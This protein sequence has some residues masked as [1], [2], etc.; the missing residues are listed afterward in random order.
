MKNAISKY[1]HVLVCICTCVPSINQHVNMI[2]CKFLIFRISSLACLPGA[3]FPGDGKTDYGHRSS[4]NEF[5]PSTADFAR[6][7]WLRNRCAA[8]SLFWAQCPLSLDDKGEELDGRLR[9][10]YAA[11]GVRPTRHPSFVFRIT[12]REAISIIAQHV[13]WWNGNFLSFVHRGGVF[14][15]GNESWHWKWNQRILLD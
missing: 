1:E 5:R 7:E 3:A 8:C 2:Y 12:K 15:F 11:R 14:V 4:K 9:D 13:L 10:L 6:L